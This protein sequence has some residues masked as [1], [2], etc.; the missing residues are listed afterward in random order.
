MHTLVVRLRSFPR[1]AQLYLVHMALL[2]FGLS[3]NILF[4]NLAIPALGYSLTFLGILN[5]APVLVAGILTLPLWWLVTRVIGLWSALFLSAICQTIAIFTIAI[6][7]STVPLLIG[8]TLTG[9][10]VVLLQISAAPFM[11]R[12]STDAERDFLFSFSAGINIG[13]DGLGKLIGGTLPGLFA[14]LLDV[15]PQSGLAYRATFALAGMCVLLSVVPLLLM[16]GERQL[17]TIDHWPVW[18]TPRMPL[19]PRPWTIDHGPDTR[20]NY[21]VRLL[22]RLLA[23]VPEPWQ[24]MLRRPWKVLRFMVTPL[25][26]SFGAAILIPYFNIYFTQRFAVS[27]EALGGIFAAMSIAT[28]L[29]TLM[30]PWLS[31][32]VGKMHSVALTQA[33]AVPCLLALGFAPWLSTAVVFAVARQTLMNMASP[34]YDA[35]AME[36]STEDTRPTVIGLINGAFG[37]GYIFGPNISV[38]VQDRYG[39]TLLFAATA[40][41]YTVAAIVNYFLFAR[42]EHRIVPQVPEPEFT[43]QE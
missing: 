37:I 33:M 41:L 22:N 29:A 12:H 19:T 28:G 25:L 1:P 3:I 40:I 32:R 7:P 11:M 8:L 9:P 10:A 20:R 21:V 39:F 17:W 18:T 27:N 34:L 13:F 23:Y 38:W 6:W 36:Q 14:R 42:R 30:A 24:S 31:T 16:R 4:F 43:I 26:I 2:T 35:Y 15:A 5:S